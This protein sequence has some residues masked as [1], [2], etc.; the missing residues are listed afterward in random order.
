M[1]R[2][3]AMML[4]AAVTLLAA[5]KFQYA[6]I[7]VNS[8]D[9]IKFLQE[10]NID[11]DRT[12][13][14]RGGTIID[15]K[16]TVYVTEEQYSL[17]EK[18]GY[19]MKWT[20]LELPKDLTEYRDNTDIGDS[21]LIWQNRYPSICKRIQIGNSAESRPLWVLKISN[22]V[23]IEEAEPE[24]KLVSTMH[25]DE[26]TG[27]EMELFLIENILKGYEANNDTMCFI[28]DNTELYV[29]PLFN[30]DGNA[31]NSR[32]N[33]N[34]IDLNR[35]FPE[36]TYYEA[37][38]AEPDEPE[39]AAMID[40]SNQH[41][42]I[43]S[44]NYH[45]GALV[46][47]YLYDKDFGVANYSYAACPDDPHVT[48]LAYNY[49]IRNEPMFNSPSF[50]DGITNG[51]EWYTIDGGMQDWNYRY[52]NDMDL[53]L[54]I[55][56]T[57]W[58][59]YS[60]I[61]GFW[62]DNRAAMFWYLSAAHKGI[63]G[64]VTDADTGDPLN[65]VIEIAGIDKEYGTDPDLGD[66]YRVLKAGTYSMT[67]S[68]PGYVSQTINN[69]VVTDNTGKFNEATEVNVQLQ[70]LPGPDID[71]NSTTILASA[72]PE[73]SVSDAFNIG[74]TGD[75]DLTYN[76][77]FTYDDYAGSHLQ[78]GMLHENDFTIFP[79]TGYSN[80]NWISFL[81]GAQVT[82]ANVTGI[83][84]SP[85][86]STA[87]FDSVFLD[88]DQNF[89]FQTGSTALIEYNNGSGW[90]QVY[91]QNINSTTAH[92]HISLPVGSTGQLRFTGYTK[93]VSGNT[94]SW[95]IDNI[96]VVGSN[97]YYTSY[98]WL[99]I[100]SNAS[101]SVTPSG[102]NIINLT[103]D[104]AGLQEGTYNANITI[105]SNDIV[106]PTL[107]LPVIFTVSDV[108]SAPLNVTVIS[109]S[110]SES[111]LAWDAVSGATLY[112]IYRS[113]DPYSGFLFLSTSVTNTYTDT[114]VSAGN[115]YFYYITAD[116][117]KK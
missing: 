6:E 84:T 31:N 15:G 2:Y 9:D 17:I 104:A 62:A 25:G 43:L 41:N 85:Q 105:N 12:S 89:S 7:K 63:Y 95:L 103:C 48:W 18:N 33:G 73:T 49:S 58:P 112:K 97:S 40:F 111:Q 4:I 57:K 68:A 116:N 77:T 35:D 24:M 27:M 50:A 42:F 13:F 53:T 44:A 23:D 70:R 67:V 34:G 108:L 21:M 99:T 19:S 69:I 26:V 59:A 47:N 94:A 11:I 51:C 80:T 117:S 78:L 81:G 114:S 22:N 92:Q 106:E 32:Y 1:N 90:V 98:T 37:N 45:G 38:I 10:N 76:I 107:I 29:M 79:G 65:A 75:A 115:K 88:F 87:D 56:N 82:G 100:N 109:V 93:K 66:Y 36:G 83:L 110:P 96:E 14:G 86:F 102:S 64:I 71:L 113:A 61:A 16:V 28:V 72:T 5:N 30:P 52:Y 101:G 46:A 20:P 39:I 8:I 55:S 74:N 91:F 54:E 60:E 3:I